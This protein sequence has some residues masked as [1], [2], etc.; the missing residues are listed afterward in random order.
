V[1]QM[2]MGFI[3]PFAL[4]FVAKPLEYFINTLR[5]VTGK[6]AVVSLR[7]LAFLLRLIGNI[8]TYLGELLVNLYDL[9]IFPPLWVERLARGMGQQTDVNPQEETT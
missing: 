1:G 6:V 4:S 9:V 8:A 2:V 7:W 3:L 5:T